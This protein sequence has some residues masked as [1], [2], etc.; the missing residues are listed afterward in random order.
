M[1]KTNPTAI[2]ITLDC[3]TA[4]L[5]ELQSKVLDKGIS[6]TEQAVKAMLAANKSRPFGIN[7]KNISVVR[8]RYGTDELRVIADK[9]SVFFNDQQSL[10]ENNFSKIIRSIIDHEQES[11][12]KCNDLDPEIKVEIKKNLNGEGKL[13]RYF[14]SSN[15]ELLNNFSLTKGFKYALI[16]PM[17]LYE[18]KSIGVLIVGA[19]EKSISHQDA[20][21]IDSFSDRLALILRFIDKKHRE[22]LQNGLNQSLSKKKKT[23]FEIIKTC[24]DFLTKDL[25]VIDNEKFPFSTQE[26]FHKSEINIIT[27]HPNN[28]RKFH[29]VYGDQSIKID[30]FSEIHKGEL[31]ELDEIKLIAGDKTKLVEKFQYTMPISL[32]EVFEKKKPI[33]CGNNDECQKYFSNDKNLKSFAIFPM[34]INEGGV[35]GYFIFKNYYESKSYESELAMLD[36]ISNNVALHLIQLRHQERQDALEKFGDIFHKKSLAY[37]DRDEYVDLFVEQLK[38]T[39]GVEVDFSLLLRDRRTGGMQTLAVSGDFYDDFVNKEIGKSRTDEI[40]K[41]FTLSQYND[42]ASYTKDFIE[43]YNEKNEPKLNLQTQDE[44]NNNKYGFK[45][46][47]IIPLH[48]VVGGS[49]SNDISKEE[50]NI[51]CLIVK[52]FHIGQSDLVFLDSLTDQLAQQLHYLRDNERQALLNNFE[53]DIRLSGELSKSD[54]LIKAHRYVDLVMNTENMFIA[55][56]DSNEIKFPLFQLDGET[57]EDIAQRAQRTYKPH[58]K[59]RARVEWVLDERDTIFIETLAESIEWYEANGHAEAVGNPYA[60]WIGA[61]IWDEDQAV[62]VIAVF[63]PSENYI[64]GFGDLDFIECLSEKVS[65]YL[66]GSKRM[67]ARIQLEKEKELEKKIQQAAIFEETITSNEV[68]LNYFSSNIKSSLDFSKAQVEQAIYDLD[69][70]IRTEDID[71]LN[72]TLDGLQKSKTTLIDGVNDFDLI[73]NDGFSRF[74]LLTLIEKVVKNIRTQNGDRLV[75]DLKVEFGKVDRTKRENFLLSSKYRI[76]LN[77]IYRILKSICSTHKNI[78]INLLKSGELVVFEVIS[79][80]GLLVDPLILERVNSYLGDLT[81]KVK[82]DDNRL[83]IAFFSNANRLLQEEI[84][85]YILD[86]QSGSIFYRWLRKELEETYDIKWLKSA[87]EIDTNSSGIYLIGGVFVEETSF[88]FND[89]SRVLI[90][91]NDPSQLLSYPFSELACITKFDGDDNFI[92]K[93]DFIE[94]FKKLAINYPMA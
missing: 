22:K 38:Y 45:S 42:E 14:M 68:L 67:I 17:R 31:I 26:W 69:E 34:L 3:A 23:R 65:L 40:A 44:N 36:D 19:T 93:F 61:P 24:T 49:S 73:T 41:A 27:R 64:Y 83:E 82:N 10:L 8:R 4:T 59:E 84:N 5:D 91:K 81:A 30:K 52:K 21:Y 78:T 88:E 79:E 18:D 15:A 7:S 48:R 12:L 72:Y 28:F 71:V 16:V 56:L 1:K 35:I 70:V 33:I 90:L 80:Y 25:N 87:N 94:K 6:T 46:S 54:V 9:G 39:Y 89:S 75:S 43:K 2:N 51:G 63:H 32:Q 50:V 55:L 77:S 57:R 92:S 74:N 66:Q 53:K 85:I 11:L 20:R 58:V 47:V 29:W 60:S 76:V 86:D 62:G 37:M 13:P